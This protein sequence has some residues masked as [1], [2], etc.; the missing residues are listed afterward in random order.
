MSY[1][2][3]G[4]GFDL[5]FYTDT[6]ASNNCQLTLDGSTDFSA[7]TTNLVTPLSGLSFTAATGILDLEPSSGSNVGNSLMVYGLPL[8][9]HTI[10]IQRGS[11]NTN[12]QLHCLDIITPIHS[13]QNNGPIILQNTLP[14]GSCA[15]Q[16]LREFNESDVR[17]NK[18]YAQAV[19]IAV[20]PT[21]TSTS[22]V[23][24]PD[25]SLTIKTTGS[26][27]QIDWQASYTNNQSAG[28]GRTFFLVAINGVTN[29]LAQGMDTQ[30]ASST[31]CNSSGSI[32]LP[33]S[34][35]THKVDLYWGVVAG[36]STAF[37]TW[38]KISVRE[39]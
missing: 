27:I 32:I 10:T 3:F 15:L 28:V 17:A 23:P 20:N 13:H 26:P 12:C 33:V 1:T 14:V 9:L 21:T 7:Y 6:T 24:M 2:F 30:N 18:P 35:G 11:D 19:G 39:I 4:T 36:T 16:D 22:A 29:S 8:G 37:S 5:R 34:A 31:V 38:R 25:M